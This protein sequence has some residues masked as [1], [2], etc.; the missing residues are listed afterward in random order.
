MAARAVIRDVGRVMDLPYQQVD[1]IA[2][3]VPFEL[4]ITL[5]KA[6]KMN[7]ELNRLYEGDPQVHRLIEMARKLEGMPRNASTHAAGVLITANPVVDY[8]PL[9]TNDDVITTQYPMGTVEAL[10][11]LKMDFLGL[12]TLNVI[13]DTIEMARDRLGADFKSEDIP[14]DEPG[15]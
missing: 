7:P 9:Q 4:N 10:G 3:Q 1:G 6:L 12:R 13:M 14:L 5:D 8:C 11:L 2:K 15:V